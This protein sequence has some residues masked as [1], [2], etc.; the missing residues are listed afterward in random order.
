MQCDSSEALVSVVIPVYNVEKYLHVCLDSVLAQSYT[1]LQVILVN[2]GSCDASLAIAESYNDSRLEVFSKSNGGLSSARNYGLAR[3]RGDYLCFVDSDDALHPD[4]VRLLLD[5]ILQTQADLAVCGLARFSCDSELPTMN[6][7][8]NGAEFHLYSQEK[9]ITEL[10]GGGFLQQFTVAVSKLYP[11]QIY[12]NLRFPEG[13]LHEDVAVALPVL[14]Q[15]Q[16]VALTTSLLYHYRCNES[17][18]MTTPSWK[19]VDGIDFYEEHYRLLSGLHMP[20]AKLALL[21][22]FKAGINCLTEYSANPSYRQDPRY[23][24]LQKRVEKLAKRIPIKGL[25]K[26]DAATVV[27]ARISIAVATFIYGIALRLK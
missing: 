6:E 4:F 1:N 20:Q 22:A 3:A 12:K 14:L 19:H 11:R 2:D 25:R 21:A 5:G 27:T 9:A 16:R 26:I 10:Y 17:S 8:V 15:A 7:V 18:I 23:R 13:R 24:S